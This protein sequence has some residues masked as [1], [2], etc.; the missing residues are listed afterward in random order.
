[1]FLYVAFHYVSIGGH[2]PQLLHIQDLRAQ[3]PPEQGA[4]GEH[5]TD[6]QG[7]GEDPWNPVEHP[8]AGCGKSSIPRHYH[9]GYIGPGGGG[10]GLKVYLLQSLLCHY[11]VLLSPRTWCCRH[12]NPSPIERLPLALGLYLTCLTLCVMSVTHSL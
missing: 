5:R 8:Q 9:S 6:G 7:E 12:K 10:G 4:V 2:R 1:M 3:R 11:L